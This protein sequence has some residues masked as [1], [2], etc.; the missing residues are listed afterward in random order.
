M[1]GVSNPG[2]QLYLTTCTHI[3]QLHRQSHYTPSLPHRCITSAAALALA[4]ACLFPCFQDLP[5]RICSSI[6]F[7]CG[8]FR[9]VNISIA[10]MAITRSSRNT[11]Y[12]MT[13]PL[14]WPSSSRLVSGITRIA[15]TAWSLETAQLW[16]TGRCP[17]LS[18]LIWPGP[19]HDKIWR[20]PGHLGIVYSLHMSTAAPGHCRDRE[21]KQR[22]AAADG[23]RREIKSYCPDNISHEELWKRVRKL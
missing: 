22:L 3:I 9:L 11:S 6:L 15:A 23:T 7:G 5:S 8:H 16:Q 14:V 4:V 18:V 21:Y 13:S 1:W 2:L 20:H 19:G 12:V 10:N 17:L